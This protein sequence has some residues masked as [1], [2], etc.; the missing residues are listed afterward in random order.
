V[1]HKLSILLFAI[2]VMIAWPTT[3]QAQSDTAENTFDPATIPLPQEPPFAPLGEAI[4][5]ENCAPCHGPTGNSDGPVVPELPNKPPLFADPETIWGKSPAE[6][7]H[8]TKFGRIEN[9]MP[10]WGNRLDDEQI[11]QAALYAWSLHT[12]ANAVATGTE[13][14]EQSCAACHGPTGMGDGPDSSGSLPNWRDPAQTYLLTQSELA[15]SLA[16][17]HPE[18]ATDLTDVDVQNLLDHLRTFSYVPPWESLFQPGEGSVDGLVQ[19]GTASEDDTEADGSPSLA[20]LTINLTAYADFSSVATFTTTADIEGRFLFTD[21]ATTPGIVYVAETRYQQINYVSDAFELTPNVPTQ[22]VRLTVFEPTSD[23][24]GLYINRANWII[25]YEPGQL[26]IGLLMNLGNELDRTYVGETVAGLDRAATLIL[27]LPEGATQVEF[28]DGVLGGRYEQIENRIYDTADVSPS[29]DTRQILM[30]YRLPV[31]GTEAQVVQSFLYPVRNLNLLVSELPDL[32]VEV[33]AL[34]FMGEQALQDVSYRLWNG[35]D[36]VEP[37]IEVKLQG[38]LAPGSMDPRNFVQ[39][40]VDAERTAPVVTTPPLDYRVPL[41]TGSFVA[42]I[43]GGVLVWSA[44]RTNKLDRMT[45]LE[46]QKAE[47]MAQIAAL[48]DQYEEGYIAQRAWSQRR[49]Q[50]KVHLLDIADQLL[51][52]DGQR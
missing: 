30:S 37:E 11:W 3:I 8:V 4:Y 18:L 47:L 44:R 23:S 40:S 31:Q 39:E 45:L 43:L 2:I 17:A 19:L 28:Q 10:P 42:L 33:S 49:A 22:T 48:D 27:E 32:D 35:A 51:T 20:E 29:P 1:T 16:T 24:S 38:V 9:L 13:I 52:A 36:L 50:M 14:Y 6:Y 26:I 15:Q 41:A 46:N 21:L 12:D 34:E 5:Q 25:D 7:F